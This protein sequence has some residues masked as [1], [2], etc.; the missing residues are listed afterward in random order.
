VQVFVIAACPV[1]IDVA[2]TWSLNPV[3]RSDKFGQ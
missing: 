2:M 1:E 3:L